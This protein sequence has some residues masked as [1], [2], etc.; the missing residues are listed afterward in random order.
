MFSYTANPA[1][2]VFGSGTLASLPDE[3]RRLGATRV[4]LLGSPPLAGPADR[5]ADSLGPLLAARFDEAAMHTPVDVT[6]RALKVVTENDVDC[7]L[8]I[9]GG[10]TTGLA[11]AIALRTD[12]PQ[13]IVPTTYAGSEMTPVLG[14]TADGRKTTQTTPKV[15]PE[16]V[17]Y[18][19]DL[20]LKLPVQVSLTSGVN[21]MAHAVEA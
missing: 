3:V 6:E 1:R 7:V 9:G 8:A 4:L 18:D 17:V 11:K 12:L 16:V 14:E 19:V 13:I 10:S 20:T 21:A 2:V 15:L 5:V